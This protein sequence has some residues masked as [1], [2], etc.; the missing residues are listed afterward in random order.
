MIIRRIVIGGASIIGSLAFTLVGS[1][2]SPANA[3]SDSPANAH[4]S[5][6][7]TPV[8]PPAVPANA[9]RL[10][11]GE[12]V[13]LNAKLGQVYIL[14]K[15]LPSNLHNILVIHANPGQAVHVSGYVGPVIIEPTYPNI[16]R[17]VPRPANLPLSSGGKTGPYVTQGSPSPHS[18][19]AQVTSSAIGSPA[20]TTTAVITVD[21]T[22]G[23]EGAGG[24]LDFNDLS[25][26]PS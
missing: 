15:R 25:F 13:P 21:Y 1:I 4:V 2:S 6:T 3:I 20:T 24:V 9:I 12:S 22:N 10:K 17:I 14:P 18:T 7:G 26:A 23:A 5:I 11:P 16:A 8:S 19:T